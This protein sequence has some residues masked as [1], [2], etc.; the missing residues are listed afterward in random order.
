[1]IIVPVPVAPQAFVTPPADPRARGPPRV[2]KASWYLMIPALANSI[3]VATI[4]SVARLYR[5]LRQLLSRPSWKLSNP[6]DKVG[7]PLGQHFD[8]EPS[9]ETVCRTV[10]VPPDLA[11][12][13]QVPTPRK[14]VPLVNMLWWGR[15]ADYSNERAYRHLPIRHPSAPVGA[16]RLRHRH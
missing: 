15:W 8:Q 12:G 1:M 5:V 9:A 13:V 16:S 2:R 6:V 3:G 10:R 4:G 14:P 7:I 11:Y